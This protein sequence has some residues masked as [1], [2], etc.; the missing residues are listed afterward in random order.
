LQWG[1]V[2]APVR[3]AESSEGVVHL[4]VSSLQTAT[5]PAPAQQGSLFGCGS[6]E[7]GVT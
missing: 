2:L 6:A 5:R 3:G 4:T 7:K 1:I